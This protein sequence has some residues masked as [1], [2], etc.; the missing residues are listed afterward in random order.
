MPELNI[1]DLDKLDI[2]D[3]IEKSKCIRVKWGK[4]REITFRPPTVII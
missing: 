4:Q 3:K 1:K 2:W